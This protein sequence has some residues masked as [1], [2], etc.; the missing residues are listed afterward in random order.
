[1]YLLFDEAQ[2][3][4]HA[5]IDAKEEVAVRELAV[6]LGREALA[7]QAEWLLTQRERPVGIV[8]TAAGQL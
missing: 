8:Q 4:L 7:E 1:M 2:R 5:A 3:E 6:A